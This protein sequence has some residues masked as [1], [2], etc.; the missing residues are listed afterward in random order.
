MYDL[1]QFQVLPYKLVIFAYC[2]QD[3]LRVCKPEHMASVYAA[4]M[5]GCSSK[6]GKAAL[7]G[8]LLVRVIHA[9]VSCNRQIVPIFAHTIDVRAHPSQGII[10]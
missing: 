7:V 5:M 6:V 3:C 2:K 8:A 4:R 10:P 9:Q 1:L